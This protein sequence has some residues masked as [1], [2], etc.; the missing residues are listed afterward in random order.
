MGKK[1]T[2]ASS[3]AAVSATAAAK[4]AQCDWTASTI[5]KHDEKKMRSLGLISDDEKDVRFPGSDSRP[6]HPTGFTVMFSA[7]LFYGLS[8]PAHE[9]LRCLLFLYGIQ[10]WQ[11]TPNS[12]LY[13]TI[14]ITVCEAFL[15]IDPHWGLWKK[16]FF[17]KRHNG[18]SGPYVVG[19]VGFVVR[20]EV[21]YFNFLMK[22]S[23]QGWRSKWF[24][25]RDRPGS[26]HRSDLPKFTDILEATPKKS[27]QNILTAEEKPVADDLYE[28]VLG[29]KN[30]GGQ[31]MIGTEIA[32]MFLKRRIQPVMSIAHQMWLYTGAKDVTQIN[33]AELSEKDLLDE[34]STV[35]RCYP[36]APET[37]EEPEDDESTGNVEVNVEVVEDSDATEDE[38]EKE[39]E[40]DE[41]DGAEALTAKPPKVST[42]QPP[43]KPS[44]I[45]TDKDDLLF[46]SRICSYSDEGEVAPP[47]FKKAKTGS[48][49]ELTA[50]AEGP[51]L[52]EGAPVAPPPPKRT[53]K[54]RKEAPS[55]AASPPSAPE[56]HPIQATVAMVRDFAA[57]FIQLKAENA[58]LREAAT[59]SAEQLEKANKLAADA[60]READK[61]KKELGQIK[62]K[63]KEEEEQKAEAQTQAKEKEGNLH[64]SIEAL[65]GAADIPVDRA[66]KLQ[67]DSMSDA[68][69]FAVDSSEQV[70][71]LLQKSKAALT[72]LF[73]LIFPK[74]DQDKTLGQLV[75][76]FFIDTDGTID[77]T[78]KKILRLVL[79]D[80]TAEIPGNEPIPWF[81]LRCLEEQWLK[82]L[83]LFTYK[84]PLV[85][86]SVLTV[87]ICVGR[88][89]GNA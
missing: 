74:L 2:T 6:N 40:K 66:S 45:F 53:Q 34:A 7:F 46:E 70:Q 61:L 64:K 9:F 21:N 19:G 47:P 20:K 72:R 63:L 81:H 52:P 80:D 27:W 85:R 41:T 17:V 84:T 75:D 25:L 67:V 3:G 68:I 73:A 26:G 23:V 8:L 60:W 89:D 12:I 33:A 50:E 88:R 14:F 44:G 83:H 71:M 13:L 18:G 28:K 82:N 35:A 59:S 30:A 87:N 42:A 36:S 49:K 79:T 78:R 15:G 32:A 62:A 43:K 48:E 4:D 29:M 55:T 11:L 1:K 57:Q 56:G 76:A 86:E 69:S 31:T 77:T 54:K 10:L 58:Q 22:D 39:K 5:T 38:E 51:T 65:R 16:I 24:Y 37:R